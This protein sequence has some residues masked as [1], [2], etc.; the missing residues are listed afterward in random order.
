MKRHLTTIVLVLFAVGLAYWV[1]RDKDRMTTAEQK[2][3]EL[4]A[5]PAW[6]KDDV[7]KIEVSHEGETIVLERANKEAPWRMKS[8]RDER[9]DQ[10]AVERLTTTFEFAT[11]VRPVVANDALGFER[12]RATGVVFMGGMTFHFVL[13]G[14][15]PRP[16]GSGYLKVDDGAPFVC[17]KE[18]TQTI[19]ADADTYRDRSVVPYLSL[20]LAKFSVAHPGGGFSLERLDARSFQVAIDGGLLLSSRKQLDQAWGALSEMRAESFP[21]DADVERLTANPRLTIRMEPKEASKGVAVLVVGDACP[22]HPED[23]VVLRKEPTRAAACAPKGAMDRLLALA[24]KDFVDD[25]PFGF[26]HDEIEELRLEAADPKAASTSAGSPAAVEIA[27]RGTGFHLREP[28]DRELVPDEADAASELLSQ[29]ELVPALS[30]KSNARAP[31]AATAKAKVRV[32]E[33][34]ELVEVGPSNAQGDVVVHRVRDDALLTMRALAARRLVPRATTFRSRKYLP[35]ETRK[36]TRVALKC[37]VEQE[38]VDEGEGFRLVKPAGY[39][40]DGSIRSLID[41][42]VRD[43]ANEWTADRDDGSFGITPDGCRLVLSYADGNSPTTLHF[44]SDDRGL[45][46]GTVDGERGVFVTSML[47]LVK[48]IYVSPK[49]IDIEPDADRVVVKMRGQVVPGDHR[50]AWDLTGASAVTLG[51]SDVGPVDV[52]ITVTGDGGVRRIVCGR[53]EDPLWRKCANPAVMAVFRVHAKAVDAMATP[54]P[55]P[56]ISDAGRPDAR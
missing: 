11:R 26:R 49:A 28:E 41:H 25:R 3:R 17:S 13:G 44:G 39:E 51:K 24:P 15:S 54:A 12:P 46:Y 22:G 7:T 48:K 9:V 42:F 52:E 43:K 6:R 38:L 53:D 40:T 4:S 23:V 34:E 30:V 36:I 1:W 31:F 10:A 35:N 2:G 33:F 5:F 14:T 19:L 55:G 56:A 27:R 16:E 21:K 45:A 8:P 29:I 20:E 37:G 50:R 32:A 47:R 18:M